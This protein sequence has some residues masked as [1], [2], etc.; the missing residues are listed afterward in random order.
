MSELRE[1]VAT[2]RLEMEVLGQTV[3]ANYRLEDGRLIIDHVE[4]PVSLRGSGAAGRF[5]AL[6]SE[7]AR[8][9]NV[10]ILPL[11]GYAAA[12]LERSGEHRDLIWRSR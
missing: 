7:H 11:C 10:K 6:V 9:A 8:A 3:F 2:G 12:W 1:N 5:M 4:A